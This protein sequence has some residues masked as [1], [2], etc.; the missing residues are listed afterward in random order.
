MMLKIIQTSKLKT[1]SET[2]QKNDD[3]RYWL[4]FE[5]ERKKFD[6]RLKAICVIQFK[7]ELNTIIANTKDNIDIQN[8]IPTTLYADWKHIIERTYEIVGKY[9]YNRQLKILRSEEFN[10]KNNKKSLQSFDQLNILKVE[11]ENNI[12]NVNQNLDNI[13][14]N[15]LNPSQVEEEDNKYW[16]LL[17]LAFLRQQISNKVQSI[18]DT[19]RNELIRVVT[20]SQASG[21]TTLQIQNQIRQVYNNYMA[22]RSLL[23]ARTEVA[24]SSNFGTRTASD[25]SG[26]PLI[27]TWIATMDERVRDAHM[28]AH[29]QTK[30]MEEPFLVGGELLKHP[31]DVSLN[32]TAKNICNCRCCER[33]YIDRSRYV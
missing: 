31:H 1:I 33:I 5:K 24:A 2:K 9:F 23:I 3:I 25:R 27:H 32:A 16:L 28:V 12:E 14:N 26:L 20:A 29:G 11:V 30:R 21:A 22:I 19:T 18:V 13:V 17:L 7:K 6:K 8:V 15:I 10:L 4:K